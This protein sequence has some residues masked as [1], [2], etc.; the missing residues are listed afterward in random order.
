M[1]LTRQTEEEKFSETI[2]K[3]IFGNSYLSFTNLTNKLTS[4]N[5]RTTPVLHLVVDISIYN[6][7]QYLIEKGSLVAIKIET[8]YTNA[9]N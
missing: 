2:P 6:R 1:S 3:L 4:L 7:K 8:D 9:S 5:I